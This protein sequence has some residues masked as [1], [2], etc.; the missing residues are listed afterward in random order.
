M[1][2]F[3]SRYARYARCARCAGTRLATGWQLGETLVSRWVGRQVELGLGAGVLL[4]TL[5]SSPALLKLVLVA[6][7]TQV[8]GAGASLA[9]ENSLYI[10]IC[11]IWSGKQV[12]F[13]V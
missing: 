10:T 7:W 11:H 8:G 6:L 3:V 12:F 2:T 4:P 9:P 1:D 5:D 13:L